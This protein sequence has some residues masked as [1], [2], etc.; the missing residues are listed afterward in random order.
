MDRLLKKSCLDSKRIDGSTDI[1]VWGSRNIEKTQFDLSY[2]T[3][4]LHLVSEL[5]RL[6]RKAF[7]VK[8]NFFD[9]EEINQIFLRVI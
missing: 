8:K 9:L 1:K 3:K 2:R 5:A 6:C 4:S 7:V